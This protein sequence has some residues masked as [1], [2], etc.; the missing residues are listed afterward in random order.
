MDLVGGFSL[1]K[2]GDVVFMSVELVGRG[3]ADV[4][5]FYSLTFAV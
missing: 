4:G 1:E 5:G 2:G 3:V